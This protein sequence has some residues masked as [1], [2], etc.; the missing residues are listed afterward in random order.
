MEKFPRSPMSPKIRGLFFLYF[1]LLL[2][3]S[4]FFAI[5]TWNP[6]ENSLHAQD[7]TQT[8][9]STDKGNK[10]IYETIIKNETATIINTTTITNIT[11]GKQTKENIVTRPMTGRAFFITDYAH[12]FINHETRL[13]ILAGL[14]GIIGAS[15]H[16]ISS[17]AMWIAT[18]K[19][20]KGWE[21]WYLSRPLLG[22]TLAIITYLMLRA[23]FVSGGPSAISD[24][25]TAG[26]SALVG[27]M[28]TEMVK[29]LMI[30]FDT[31]FGSQK[32]LQEK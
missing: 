2:A 18:G 1:F 8:V 7:N 5:S 6:I 22:A 11:N 27:M 10:I 14:F 30:I 32:S 19:L 9:T 29:K 21:F 23:G 20:E 28:T 4:I 16:G 17:L 15:L 13:I 3:I 12:L 24:F 25:G 31:L 26:I